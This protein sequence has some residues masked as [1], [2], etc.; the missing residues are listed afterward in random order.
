MTFQIKT[1][2]WTISCALVLIIVTSQQ[3][4][5]SENTHYLPA[6]DCYDLFRQP[7][8]SIYRTNGHS[9][10]KLLFS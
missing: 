4:S 6:L 10:L 7:Q 5:A 8:V 9:N 1:K 3:I 2:L